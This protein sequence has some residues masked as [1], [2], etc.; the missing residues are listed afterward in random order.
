MALLLQVVAGVL[1]EALRWQPRAWSHLGQRCKWKLPEPG[2]G[3]AV[4]PWAAP[5]AQSGFAAQPVSGRQ[6]QSGL[7]RKNVLLLETTDV[8]GSSPRGRRASGT[9]ALKPAGRGNARR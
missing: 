1:G 8:G 3:R 7:C 5:V 9:H 4:G 2:K 6:S